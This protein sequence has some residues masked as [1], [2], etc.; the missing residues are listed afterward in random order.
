MSREYLNEHYRQAVLKQLEEEK[1]KMIT[2]V[3]EHLLEIGYEEDRAVDAIAFKMEL[4][5]KYHELKFQENWNYTLKEMM[6][7]KNKDG[8]VLGLDSIAMR[9]K[10]MFGDIEDWEQDVYNMIFKE[11]EEFLARLNDYFEFEFEDLKVIIKLWMYMTFGDL[12][13]ITYSFSIVANEDLIGA[14]RCLYMI[15]NPFYDEKL[16]DMIK[17]RY[18]KIDIHFVDTREEML[19][20]NFIVLNGIYDHM[21]AMEKESGK[22]AY[23]EHLK[24]LRKKDDA[25]GI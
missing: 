8:I 12:Y 4:L 11:F 1:P 6:K 20:M 16:M 2:L 25:N 7:E 19:R 9:T 10:D 13:E 14:A 15:S 23:I 3:Y 24:H 5:A 21:L 18:P 22:E 17:K